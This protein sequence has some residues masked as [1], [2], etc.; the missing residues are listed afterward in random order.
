MSPQEKEMT[1]C[2]LVR[3]TPL[4]K[5]VALAAKKPKLGSGGQW[6]Y[7]N[8]YGGKVEPGQ[9]PQDSALEEL[10]KESGVNALA[11]Y[12]QNRGYIDFNVLDDVYGKDAGKRFRCYMYILENFQ[13]EL[14][15]T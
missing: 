1:L 9:S 3:Q 12:L 10:M 7:V 5:E 6:S 2:F 13:A 14:H 4:G 15:E 8:G 11:H